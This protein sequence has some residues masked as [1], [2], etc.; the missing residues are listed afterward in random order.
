M[1]FSRVIKYAVRAAGAIT[2]LLALA[3]YDEVT[4]K[5]VLIN[6]SPYNLTQ[7]RVGVGEADAKEL[8][9]LFWTGD[10]KHGGTQ[11]ISKV[12][13]KTG[14]LAISFT[15]NGE[16][17]ALTYGYVSGAALAHGIRVRVKSSNDVVVDDMKTILGYLL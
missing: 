4:T 7:V 17:V 13:D 12:A 16:K 2:I 3:I 1:R 10:I 5:V 11:W 14:G 8:K 9:E 6:D 15:I